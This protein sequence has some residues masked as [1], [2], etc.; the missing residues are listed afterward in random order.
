LNRARVLLADD[1]LLVIN[2]VGAL[3]SAAFDLVGT[4]RSGQQLISEA[5]RLDPDVVVADV[6]M[7]EMSGIEA[8]HRL[9]AAGSRARFVFLTIHTEAEFIDACLAEGAAGYVFK[10]QM[11]SDLIAAVRA[12]LRGHRF[13]SSP[14]SR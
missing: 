7:P 4:A 12:A 9:R 2:R 8:V 11:K 5:L 13:I 14:S 10:S 6:T 1:H 3:L